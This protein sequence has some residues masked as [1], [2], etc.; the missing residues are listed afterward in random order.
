M[1]HF[2]GSRSSS[3]ARL[4]SVGSSSSKTSPRDKAVA[5][6]ALHASLAAAA[7]SAQLPKGHRALALF[8]EV[9]ERKHGRKRSPRDG[10]NPA[11][12]WAD[13]LADTQM[14]V[15]LGLSVERFRA[16]AE[17]VDA[18]VAAVYA[19]DRSCDFLS[20]RLRTAWGVEVPFSMQTHAPFEKLASPR[21]EDQQ[22][23]LQGAPAEAPGEQGAPGAAEEEAKCAGE[24][25]NAAALMRA[26]QAAMK[27]AAPK[28]P[29]S[30]AA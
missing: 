23:L 4:Q 17:G 16:W 20:A 27:R 5:V 6:A 12:A 15:H 25:R 22:G 10:F 14:L 28:M 8:V 18:A 13:L 7:A 24:P 3:D 1:V 2:F 11:A 9:L 29:V 19:D 26:R 30:S 21:P